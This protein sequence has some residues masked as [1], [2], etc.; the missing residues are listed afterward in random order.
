MKYILNRQD[1]RSASKEKIGQDSQDLKT[2][3][4]GFLL[5]KIFNPVNPEKSC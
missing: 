4:T 1:A 2:G 5:P 3:L